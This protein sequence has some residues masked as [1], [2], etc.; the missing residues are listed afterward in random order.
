MAAKRAASGSTGKHKVRRTGVETSAPTEAQPSDGERRF[1]DVDPWKTPLKQLMV[2]PEDEPAGR[3]G[4]KGEGRARGR[5]L[6]GRIDRSEP[7]FAGRRSRYS[8]GARRCHRPAQ[9]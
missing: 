5:L 9:V 7:R 6:L 8:A 3:K 1:V 2:V 4:G